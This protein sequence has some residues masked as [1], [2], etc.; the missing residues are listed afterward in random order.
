MSGKIILTRPAESSRAF[1]AEAQKENPGIEAV[2]SPVLEIRP[3]SFD[4]PDTRRF[5]TLVFTS[6]HAA[7]IFPEKTRA[8]ENATVLAVGAQTS[9]AAR[10]AGYKDV[11]DAGGTTKTLLDVI[12]EKDLSGPF[13][14]PRGVHVQGDLEGRLKERGHE[15]RS[16]EV[17][18]AVKIP[19]L[20]E[21]ALYAIRNGL[22]TSVLLFSPRSAGI[23]CENAAQAGLSDSFHTINALCLSET[24][25]KSLLG[26]SWRNISVAPHPDRDGMLSLL[27]NLIS[28]AQ[29]ASE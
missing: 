5:K 15:C 17:Y 26:L 14:Y 18:E 28:G 12:E 4:I 29:A 8:D 10:E 6:A 19:R 23:F 27:G 9:Q 22:I 16:I 24:V 11:I 2:I 21:E 25:V 20:S 3:V 1:L 13:L 7:R